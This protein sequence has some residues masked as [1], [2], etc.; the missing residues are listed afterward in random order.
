MLTSRHVGPAEIADDDIVGAAEGPE[1]DVLDVVQVHRDVRDVAEKQ[2]ASAIRHDVDVLGR[3][4]AEEQHRVGAV[5]AFDGVV[6]VA[7]V[8]LEHVV[9]GAEQRDVVAVVAEHE[10]VAVAAKDGVGALAAE[11]GVVAGARVDRELDDAGRHGGGGDAVVAA[12]PSDHERVVRSLGIG[13]V[14]LRSPGRAPRP[15]FLL[16]TRRRCRS[17]WCR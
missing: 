8:P 10:V 9:A 1:F 6:A 12:G 14:D 3:V 7:R 15:S 16:R 11:D 4:G 2:R 17:H 5:L 13:D